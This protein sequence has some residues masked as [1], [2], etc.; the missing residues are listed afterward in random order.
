MIT[1]QD[2][3]HCLAELFPLDK[4]L[5][6]CPNG[7]QI[8]GKEQIRKIAFAVTANLETIEMAVASNADALI[9]HHGLFWKN[10]PLHIVGPKRK[11]LSLLLNSGISLFAYHLPLDSHPLLG[12]NWRAAGDLGWKR[13]EPFGASGG[14]SIGVKGSFP[15]LSIQEFVKTLVDYFGHKAVLAL[16]GKS[17]VSSAAL[18]SGGAHRYIEQAALEGVDCFITG[19]YDLPVW[20][21]AHEEKINFIAMGHHATEK[22][23]ILALKE[24]LERSLSLPCEFIDIPNPF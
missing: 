21:I 5:D 12:N 10:E 1:L 16:G 3:Y 9:V 17:E 13:L 20:D 19:S 14:V 11:K 7:L 22:I 2:L 6:A 4:V 15:T 8:E 18:I 24:H 23:G